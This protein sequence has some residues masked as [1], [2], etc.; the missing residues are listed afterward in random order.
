MKTAIATVS[1]PGNLREKLEAIAKAGF[2]GI[3]IFEQ[4]FIADAGA[5][6]EIGQ[7]VRDHGLEISLFQPF[8]DFEGLTGTL[9]TRAFDRA[10]L[11]FDTMA[12]LGAELMLICSTVHPQSLG[13]IDRAADDFAEL[14]QIAAERGLRVGFEALAW[15]RHVNDHRD[16]WEIVRRADHP[17]VGLIVDSFHTLSRRIDPDTIRRIPGDRIFFVQLAD[18]PRID[19]D[20]LYWSRHFRNMPG[21]GDL[22]VTEFMRA[23]LATG[24]DG[25][26]S[27]EI[28][29]DQ[30]RGGRPEGLARDGHR[31]LVALMDDVRRTEPDIAAR[32][33]QIPARVR[34]EGFAFVEFASQGAEA[35]ALAALL[36]AMGFAHVGDHIAKDVAL[37]QQGA[38]RIV[39][40]RET[41]GFAGSA[42]ALH[43]TTVCD[44]GLQVSDVAATTARAAALGAT[45]FSQPAGPGEAQIP[46][47]RNVGGSILHFIDAATWEKVWESEFRATGKGAE[48]EAG[49]GL[50]GIDHVAETMNYDEMLSWALFYTSIFEMERAAMVDVID[51]DGLVRSQAIRATGGAARLTLN[52]AETHRTLAGNI[53]AGSFGG[54]VQHVA[55]ASD[56]IHASARAMASAGFTALP[57]PGNYYDDLAARFALPPETVDRLRAHDILYDEDAR[58]V[59]YQFYSRPFA[60]GLFF[61]V[62][63]RSGDYDGYGA[64]NAP[65]R[66]AAQKRLMR[67]KGMP[68]R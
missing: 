57:M 44:V 27:L 52:G 62:V 18:A 2:D 56:D 12:E 37:W 21:E 54:A 6:R 65:F 45:A 16:A 20:L 13:G 25:P 60:G 53:L 22:P 50:T 46:A 66:I 24:Y 38:A 34:A 11:K 7:M 58:G 23:V 3:E 15:G 67:P 35:D 33:P 1:I 55:F 14:G 63:Q 43:G 30:F 40:N 59:F 26:V 51:P 61:E 42:F 32:L 19:M 39:L 4:D 36:A 47:I 8:R 31:S 29:N 9:R 10:R 48:A 49:A 64:P 5:P 28:F 41:A 17:A 68:A